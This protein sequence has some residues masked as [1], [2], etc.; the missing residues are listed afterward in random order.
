MPL[1]TDVGA[2]S[3]TPPTHSRH[4]PYHFLLACNRCF[5]EFPVSRG[6]FQPRR[7]YE[8]PA[9]NRALIN[10]I[11]GGTS[12]PETLFVAALYYSA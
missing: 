6:A 9:S 12:E 5:G 7:R 1:G 4:L 8:K 11:S 2:H 3:F 10:V